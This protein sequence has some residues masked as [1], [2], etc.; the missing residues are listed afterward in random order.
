MQAGNM[1]EFLS[2]VKG[3]PPTECIQCNCLL[4]V[5]HLLIECAEFNYAKQ[6]FYRV[7]SLQ[8]LFKTFKADVVVDYLKA[9]ALYMLL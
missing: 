9:A 5:K 4:T 7:P 2:S 6:R 1:R 3:E 8:D